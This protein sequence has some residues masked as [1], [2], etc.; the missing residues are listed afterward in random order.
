MMQIYLQKVPISNSVALHDTAEL[1][2]ELEA[3]AADV[4]GIC[5]ESCLHAIDHTDVSTDEEV[6][7][8]DKNIDFAIRSWK[9]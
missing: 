6:T 1:L 4:K 7:L 8:K 2:Y 3:T 5:S 9:R